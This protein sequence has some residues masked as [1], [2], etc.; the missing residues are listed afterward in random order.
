MITYRFM[1][2]E[3]FDIMCLRNMV[4][5]IIPL[6]LLEKNKVIAFFNEKNPTMES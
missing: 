6:I 5:K 2:S 1:L 3:I 4:P